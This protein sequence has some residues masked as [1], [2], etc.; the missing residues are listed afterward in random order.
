MGGPSTLPTLFPV[1]TLWTLAL[2]NQLTFPPA[3][4]ATRAF[5][6]IAGDR[7]VAYEL[8]AGEQQWIV[9]AQPQVQ[10][11]AGDGLLVVVEPE[12][13][14]A[15]AAEDGSVRWQLPLSEKL[16]QRPVWDSG[17]LIVATTGGTV[18]AFRAADGHL[19]W[20]REIGSPAH[21][22]PA[23][24]ADRVYV[25]TADG[26]IVALVVE[27]GA[28]IW[29]RRLG[30]APNEVLARDERLYAGATDNYFYCLM[31]K[32]GRVDWRWRTG[33]DTVGV[34]VADDRS[35]YFVALDN[36][37]RALDRTTG[38]QHWMRPLPLRPT[39]GPVQAGRTLIVTGQAP[40]LRG[41]NA[42]DG[43]AAGEIQAG[44]DMAAPPHV[45]ADVSAMGPSL[46][47][48]TRDL[49]KG[50]TV[51]LATRSV[52]PPESPIAPLPDAVAVTPKSAVER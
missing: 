19:I 47:Y 48:I 38:G 10:P 33:G 46:I 39:T 12:R 28:P 20:S 25:P 34:P 18:H 21:A 15:L 3:Y 24:A 16:A 36:V 6:A 30:G 1:R 35:V 4:D 42:T 31:A 13:L 29:E 5:F 43:S 32:D 8:K 44:P 50:A 52:E 40:I 51:T 26:R 49:G 2:N 37:L 17:W 23:L 9:S 22:L 7:I 14:A 27:T 45:V 41:Y 11:V